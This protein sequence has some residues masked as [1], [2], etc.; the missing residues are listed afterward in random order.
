M[1]VIG[2]AVYFR[3]KDVLA[4]WPKLPQAKGVHTPA[5][6]LSTNDTT[7]EFDSRTP[8]LRKNGN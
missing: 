3:H 6:L 1:A 2:A 4:L 5:R 7:T 8:A